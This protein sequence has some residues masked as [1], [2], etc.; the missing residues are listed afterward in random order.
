MTPFQALY[1]I[2]PPI[3][4]PYLPRDSPVAV[5]DRM[6]QEKEDM[7]QVLKVQ[8]ARAQTRMK[9]FADKHRSE[10]EFQIRDW[11]FL[12]LHPYKQQSMRSGGSYKLAAK[13][14][15]PFRVKDRVGKVAYQ[16]ELPVGAQI[17]DVFHVSLLKRA[18][19]SDWQFQPLPS[20]RDSA[21][22][23]EPMAIERR[24]VKRGNQAAAQL[25]IHWKNS[26]PAEATWEFASEIRHRF[27]TFVLEDR[28]SGMGEVV[29][30]K[31]VELS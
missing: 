28:D 9:Q 31:G 23:A 10:R 26:S 3:H 5:V 21:E 4:I 20:V 11:V 12:K 19:G 13:F 2:L 24:M 14:Y 29:M 18:Y 7:I 25:L 8:L 27:P 6:L 22:V 17:H 30:K 16:L 1:G 15:G